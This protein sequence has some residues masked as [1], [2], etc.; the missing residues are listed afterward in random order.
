[1]LNPV[2]LGL[3]HSS[4]VKLP[5]RFISITLPSF[6]AEFVS[7]SDYGNAI[8]TIQFGVLFQIMIH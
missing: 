3:L 7:T 8:E 4:P 1:M 6:I 2:I 5:I